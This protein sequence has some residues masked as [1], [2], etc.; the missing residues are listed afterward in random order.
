[1]QYHSIMGRLS[2]PPAALCAP[3]NI[4]FYFVRVSYFHI[5]IGGCARRSAGY[6]WMDGWDRDPLDAEKQLG[7]ARQMGRKTSEGQLFIFPSTDGLLNTLSSIP[8]VVIGQMNP[9]PHYY[10]YISTAS[11]QR[12]HYIERPTARINNKYVF[13]NLIPLSLQYNIFCVESALY[14]ESAAAAY[15]HTM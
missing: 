3:G 4:I 7:R 5:S 8:P 1:M 10:Y 12:S 13:H 11:A 6:R 14:A 9:G 15:A 2:Q